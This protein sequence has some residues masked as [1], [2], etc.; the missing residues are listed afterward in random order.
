[1]VVELPRVNRDDQIQ[2][3]PDQFNQTMEELE[4]SL[5]EFDRKMIDTNEKIEN[6]NKRL[7]GFYGRL[8]EIFGIFVAIFSL[9][10][11]TGYNISIVKGKNTTETVLN[12]FYYLT[13]LTAL[14]LVFV[15]L[16]NWLRKK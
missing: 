6:M 7:D 11:V 12:V 1:M 14:L 4:N 8:I 2:R 16:L 13:P 3:F 5:N 15:L 9:I 10:L